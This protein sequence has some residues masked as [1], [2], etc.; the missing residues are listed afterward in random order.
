M[1]AN[2]YKRHVLVLPEDDANRQIAN[3]FFLNI[4]GRAWQV[5]PP[6]GGWTKVIDDLDRV[7][8][9]TMRQYP[10]RNIVLMMDFDRQVT[11]RLERVQAV[12][13]PEL[14]DRVFVLGVLSEPEDLKANLKMMTF[15]AI[16]MSLFQDCA[17]DTRRTWSH[18]LLKHNEMEV[19]R[20]VSSVKP[21]LFS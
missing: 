19:D 10:D 21:F 17:D 18:E 6:A 5:L 14:R 8:V 12:T 20:L 1:S 13:P 7:H 15:E 4:A 11:E 2:R 3:G 16:G 9:I